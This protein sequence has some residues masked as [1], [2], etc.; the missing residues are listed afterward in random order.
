MLQF[1]LR[2]GE[3]PRQVITTTPRPIAL[4][5]RLIADPLTAVTP[6]RHARQCAHLAPAFLDAVVGALRRH[7]ARPPGARRRAHRGARRRAVV[8]RA[9]RS[10]PRRDAPP[11]H[12]HRGGGRS[13]GVRR[14]RA[15]RLR[16]RRR[17]A[18][19]ARRVYVLA[20]DTLQRALARRLG[21]REAI[22]LW[23]RLDADCLVVE[24]NQG[25]DMVRAVIARGRRRACRCARC[26]RRA[27]S[28][29]A[30]SRSRRSTS[31]AG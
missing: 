15:G 1:G 26:G 3:R 30:P 6:C 2:L 12:A 20:D 29:C 13:A 14:T 23:R 28:G 8:A 18:R 11:L 17:G 22:A 5:K 24:V 4:I 7:A 21:A 16:H 9:D 31:R 27:A 10:V 19:R 25:G